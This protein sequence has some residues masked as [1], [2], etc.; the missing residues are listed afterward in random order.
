MGLF[1]PKKIIN[2][3]STLYNMA[4][5]END[6]PDFLKGT[7]FAGAIT[8]NSSLAE[9]I[10][11]SYFNG[12]GMKQRQF[13]R[14]ANRTNL[15]TIPSTTIGNTTNIDVDVVKG[16]MTVSPSPAGLQL[17][18]SQAEVSDGDFEPFLQRW[19]LEN[20]PDRIQEDWLG[21]YEPSTEI[22][23][24]QFPNGD[25]FTFANNNQYNKNARYIMARFVEFLEESEDAVV[26]GIPTIVTTLPDVTSFNQSTDTPS[27]TPVTLTRNRTTVKSYNNGNPDVTTEDNVSADVSDELRT[28]LTIWERIVYLNGGS[29]QSGERQ[30]W[31]F[32]GADQ[33][34]GGYTN[35]IVTTKDLGGGVIETTTSTTTG[36]Q[37]ETRWN[38]RYDTQHLTKGEVIGGDQIFI[39]EV[40]TGNAVLDALVQDADASGFQ[41]FFPF[42]P[43]RLNN[44]SILADQYANIDN[45][46]T[47]PDP[48]RHNSPPYGDGLYS[49]TS[50]AFRRA[51]QNKSF[52]S[53]VESVED[54]E[55]IDDIDYAYIMFGASLNVKENAC[56]K[57]IWNFMEN[58][59]PYQVAGS[60]NA[61]TQF[62][63]DVVA[64]EA[65]KT[66]YEAWESTNW[67][68]DL[69]TMIPPKPSVPSLTPPAINK[70]KLSKVGQPYDIRLN[71]IHTEIEQFS[72]TYDNDPDVIGIQTPKKDEFMF[73]V[74]PDFSWQERT[75]YKERGGEVIEYITKTIPSMYIYWQVDSNNYR[76]MQIWGFV[77]ENYIYG[78]KAVTIT[79]TEAI[80]DTEESGFIIPLHY[81]TISDMNIVDYTQMATA[82]THILFNSYTV[83]K[84]KWYQLEIFKILLVILIIVIAVVVFP[85]AFVAGG[86]LLGGNLAV[87]AAL[88]LTGTA[89]LVAGVV[90]NYIAS[91]IISQVL[92]FVGTTL[93]GEKWGALF[94]AIAGFALSM[95]ISGTS[96]FSAEGILGLGN[97]V[98]NGYSGY[99]A[100][101]I[102]EMQEDLVSDQEDYERRMDDIQDLIDGLG[103][104]DLNFNPMFLTSATRN[105][106]NGSKGY[107]PETADQ[108]I[109]R[110]TMSGSDVVD[111]TFSMVYDFVDVQK[112]LPRN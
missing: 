71:W 80:E 16:Q 11:G 87:G 39:Y 82:N 48:N 2:V 58:L 35:T 4:G 94:A 18:I 69:W 65:A 30:I 29:S 9:D 112:T 101:D 84:Q 93:F 67:G 83:T 88:G 64:Y 27:F 76:R 57:Y 92:S 107:L 55:S 15:S 12:P 73:S 106:G 22:F 5:D 109:R 85:G 86:G 50:K 20:H 59:I 19:I 63:A 90:A 21:E 96:L 103:G 100:G 95:G 34:I 89:A 10:T 99:V 42:L 23:S 26:E 72:G 43:V 45:T 24:V 110:T 33:V 32:T 8:D 79:S 56:K 81:P 14:W 97:A 66:E 37:V 52:K 7:I 74:G 40:G 31:N 3:S 62:Q 1:S 41:E 53:L 91:I 75:T 38:T 60:G 68:D 6:R 78:G 49:E 104:N 77:H 13:F 17:L 111:L 46:G 105:R 98:A 70:I 102:V 108:Y 44:V 36:E 28:D 51:F 61:M 54:N 25:F 47:E